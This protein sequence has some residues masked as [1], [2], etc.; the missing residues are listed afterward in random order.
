MSL[1]RTIVWQRELGFML[2]A[3]LLI[4]ACGSGNKRQLVKD[5]PFISQEYQDDR[6]NSIQLSNKPQAVISLAPNITEMIFSIGAED[7]L[8]ARS[9]ACDFPDAAL[10]VAEITTYPQLDLEAL[11]AVGADLLITT[12]EIFTQDDIQHL[13]RLQIPIY[14]QSYASLSD[15]YR[16]MRDL[17]QLLGVESQ[18]RQV[19]DSLEAL[20]SRITTATENQIKYRTLILI[21]NDPLK[22]VGGTGFLNELIGKAGGLNVFGEMEEAYPT[23]SVEAI[24]KAQPEFLILPSTNDQIYAN[25][26]VQYP[27]LY[28]TPADVQK[29]VHVIEPDLLYRPGPRMVEGLMRLTHILHTKLNP[30]SFL[31]GQ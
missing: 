13:E 28:N 26:L 8:A 23:V 1:I 2:C 30:Q 9:Q 25:L 21:S 4:A 7:K 6:G 24:L 22:V 18:A 15:V 31:N 5:A 12:D 17:G 16:C 20:E 11:K 29:Q 10:N 19:A 27:A 3:C 14:Q